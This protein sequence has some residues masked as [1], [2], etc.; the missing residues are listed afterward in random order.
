MLFMP[1]QERDEALVR[2][3]IASEKQFYQWSSGVLGPWPMPAGTLNAFYREWKQNHKYLVFCGCDDDMQPLGQ[4]I[5]RYPDEDRRHVRFG[6]ILIDP[7]RRGQGLG[8]Q[9]LE[10]AIRYAREFLKAED[11]CLGVYSNNPGAVALYEKLGFRDTGEVEESH[12]MGEI[13]YCREMLL[14]L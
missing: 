9:M 11:V 3:W 6:F 4:M 7:A 2:S 8:R 10:L 14:K 12:Y 13:W 1:Y 5:L